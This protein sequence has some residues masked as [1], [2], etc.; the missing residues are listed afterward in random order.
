MNISKPIQ[1]YCPTQN[2][3]TIIDVIYSHVRNNE[4]LQTGADCEFASYGNC[5]IMMECPI[6][7]SASKT[8]FE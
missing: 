1:G 5:P 8:I 4:Y 2:K 7:Q 3:D 6:R